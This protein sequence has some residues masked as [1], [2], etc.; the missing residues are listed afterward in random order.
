MDSG[1]FCQWGRRGKADDI[2]MDFFAILIN[3]FITGRYI[4]ILY[5]TIGM[6]RQL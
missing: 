1:G 2:L 5:F 4:G 6:E 3:L